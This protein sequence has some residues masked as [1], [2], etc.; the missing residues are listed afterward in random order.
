MA[1]AGRAGH[2]ARGGVEWP[3]ARIIGEEGSHHLPASVRVARHVAERPR[4]REISALLLIRQLLHGEIS[5]YNTSHFQNP[6][7]RDSE[8][9]LPHPLWNSVLDWHMAHLAEI[10][11]PHSMVVLLQPKKLKRSYRT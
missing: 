9:L 1:S 4:A 11:E 3:S 10:G 6:S 2:V 8:Y 7:I 5:S